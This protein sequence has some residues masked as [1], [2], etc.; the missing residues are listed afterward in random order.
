MLCSDTFLASVKATSAE[1]EIVTKARVRSG[2]EFPASVASS[3]WF[4]HPD[5]VGMQNLGQL[6]VQYEE[7]SILAEIH[8]RSQA[9]MTDPL[10]VIGRR[11]ES[12]DRRATT[13]N[14]R[15]FLT[16]RISGTY[17]LASV[18]GDPD[19]ER[20]LRNKSQQLTAELPSSVT[21]WHAWPVF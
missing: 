7:A 15:K 9:A 1:Q 13:W 12:S 2:C 16:L 5:Q 8:F 17:D 10:F 4:S 20:V 19:D 14:G 6:K 18:A 11:A 3:Q 21:E